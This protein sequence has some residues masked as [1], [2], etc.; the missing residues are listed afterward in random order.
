MIRLW[1]V[2]VGMVCALA[3]CYVSSTPEP[4]IVVSHLISLLQDSQPATRQTAALSLGK[5][6]SAEAVPGLILALRDTD[7]LVRQY[8]AWALGNVGEQGK[9]EAGVAL[10]PLLEDPIPAAA[11]AAA[12]A[13]GSIG[14]GPE[15][16][17]RMLAI[18][19]EGSLQAR[20]AAVLGLGL[21]ESPLAYDGF[22][23]ALL[24]DDVQV[25]QRAIAALGEL[26]ERRAVPAIASR[27]QHDSDA[28]VR[29]EA[30]YRLGTLGDESVLP[31]LRTAAVKDS[32][33][34]VRR[35]AQWAIE[36]LSSLAEHGSTT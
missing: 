23:H 25:R 30:A 4:E 1:I 12:Q 9:A 3:G 33:E 16:M 21:L 24:Q 13:I 5:I 2:L 10:L 6:A 20:R 27:L 14:A 8:S 18:L 19:T 36:A 7:P 29:T 31:V 17:S 32:S 34:Q 35:W 28:G 26:G 11:E 22:L 15:V